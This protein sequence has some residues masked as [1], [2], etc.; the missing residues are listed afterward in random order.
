MKKIV[1]IN[2]ISIFLCCGIAYSVEDAATSKDIYHN[3]WIDLNKNNQKDIYEDS[4]VN[5]EKRIDD[6]LSKMSM[7]EKTCQMCNVY[8][9][10]RILDDAL[11]TPQWKNKIWKDGMGAIDEHLNGFHGWG[12]PPQDSP[13]CWPASKHAWAMNEVQRFFIEETRLGIPVDFT[14][15]HVL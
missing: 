2:C 1:I 14:D 7:E 10:Q 12:R 3:G 9:Y 15:E 8:G 11:P 13:Y 4:S 6:L 5:I